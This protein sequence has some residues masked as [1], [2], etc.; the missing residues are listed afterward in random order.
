MREK[1][2]ELAPYAGLVLVAAPVEH[3][4]GYSG[5]IAMLGA[6]M[7]VNIRLLRGFRKYNTERMNQLRAEL[8]MERAR[9]AE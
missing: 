3:W 8:E 7:Y 9:R 4:F 6:M 5:L 2:M 1:F